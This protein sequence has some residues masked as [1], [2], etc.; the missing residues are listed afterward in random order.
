MEQGESKVTLVEKMYNIMAELDY[1]KKDKENTFHRYTY[2]SEAA[3][4]NAVHA[5]LTKYRVMFFPTGSEVVSVERGFGAKQDENM[6]TVRLSYEFINVD[7]PAEKLA[8]QFQGTGA[9]KGDKGAYK[10]IT[11]AL[12]YALT[13]TFLIETG[14]D[15][16][17]DERKPEP[18]AA[19]KA[20]NGHWTDGKQQMNKDERAQ[21]KAEAQAIAQNK[22]Q[23][24]RKEESKPL[25]ERS[26]AL[27]QAL[28]R[29]K[30]KESGIAVLNDWVFEMGDTV[31]PEAVVNFTNFYK[32]RL[33]VGSSADMSV[34]QLRQCVEMIWRKIDQHKRDNVI[35]EAVKDAPI[36]VGADS[37]PL[38]VEK[39][40]R[41]TEQDKLAHTGYV[42]QEK[43]RQGRR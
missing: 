9:D 5:A 6:T 21:A 38:W 33:G 40:S 10:A 8:G 23:E 11:G 32:S 37:P 27:Q 28:D 41:P 43:K 29:I 18:T 13:S 3:I 4:K 39:P 15:P 35:A 14:D 26:P 16:E 1:I 17:R 42:E 34:E 19:P 25:V 24:I 7:N 31:G 30:D 2:A 12:K 36:G 22:V 20:V